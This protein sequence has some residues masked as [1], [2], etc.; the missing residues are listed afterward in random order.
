[1]R[2]LT[3][4]SL[5]FVLTL[6]AAGIAPAA[7]APG[8]LDGLRGAINQRR[9]ELGI[10][11]NSAAKRL[12]KALDRAARALQD[13]R[14]GQSR[15]HELNA[16]KRAASQLERKARDEADVLRVLGEVV[17]EYDS[18]LVEDARVLRD[19]VGVD[20][21]AGV[22]RRKLRKGERR[23]RKALRR[24]H[25]ASRRSL[26]LKFLVAADRALSVLPGLGDGPGDGGDDGGDGGG[27]DDGGG[28]PGRSITWV[29]NSLAISAAGTGFDLDGDGTIDN[30]LARVQGMLSPLNGGLIID[31]VIRQNIQT[32]ARLTVL[33]MW[34]VHSLSND[35]AVF[36]G[37]LEPT[38][39]DGV[40]TDN[41]SGT[42][43]FVA[44][45]GSL[46]AAG[47]ALTGAAAAITNGAYVTTLPQS[48]TNPAINTG[49][50]LGSSIRL[51]GVIPASAVTNN[52][53]LAV[54]FS[55]NDVALLVNAFL[56]PFNSHLAP[57][58]TASLLDV[59]TTGNGIPDSMSAA[60]D[61]TSVPCAIR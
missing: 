8:K 16:A 27:G 20:A 36:L 25:K 11:A 24:S 15:R 17:D 4:A 60:F 38:D 14:A 1:M 59:D 34:D 9:A 39:A 18:L 6:A 37:M 2:S 40:A 26:Q 42:E 23:A 48:L 21:D 51:R 28:D 35:S 41:F 12:A 49:I 3:R 58:I 5:V 50:G 33:Q 46:D 10:P 45:P 55:S 54:I 47:H 31:G 19:I 7:D 29:I 22:V 43:E 57:G 56:P 61:F 13:E 30:S 32:G 53:T 52:G 44:V